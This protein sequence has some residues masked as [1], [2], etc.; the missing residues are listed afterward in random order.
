MVGKDG[1]DSAFDFY[2][3]YCGDGAGGVPVSKSSGGKPFFISETGA[4]VHLAITDGK[5]GWIP[6]NNTDSNTRIAIKRAWWRQII[7]ST[8]LQLHPRIKGVGLFEFVKYEEESWRD[9]SVLGDGTGLHSPLRFDG[10]DNNVLVEFRKD[11]MGELDKLVIWGDK[12][13]GATPGFAMIGSS[14]SV[15][16]IMLSTI[17]LFL[18]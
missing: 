3:M 11:M 13:I 15:V 18:F 2:R 5:G 17:L 4:A 1:F 8:F 16:V 14:L 10:A 7:N 12:Q 9:F 6:A